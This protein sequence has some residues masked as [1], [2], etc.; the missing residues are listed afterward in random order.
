M[1]LIKKQLLWFVPGV[2]VMGLSTFSTLHISPTD[3]L[4][5]R[6]FFSLKR[7]NISSPSLY[8]GDYVTFWNA[9]AQKSL[10]KQVMGLPGDVITIKHGHVFVTQ[11]LGQLQKTTLEEQ[12]LTP[13]NEGIIPK[14]KVYVRG[15]H[16]HSVDSRYQE[17]GLVDMAT[18]K[19]VRP[20][21]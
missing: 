5:Y 3:S 17:V 15:T 7:G 2:I 16:P 10:S 6:V 18:L 19:V 21:L 12:P 4:P 13:I 11:D 14:G 9:W 20:L 8:R 1:P